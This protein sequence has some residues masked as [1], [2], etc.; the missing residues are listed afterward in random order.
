MP[1]P[2]LRFATLNLWGENGPWP[3][4]FLGKHKKVVEEKKPAVPDKK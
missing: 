2:H 1:A 3:A 4:R